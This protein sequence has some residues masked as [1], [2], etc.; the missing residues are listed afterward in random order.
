MK[1]TQLAIGV[2]ALVPLLSFGQEAMEKPH[3]G[4]LF[5]TVLE[6]ADESHALAL[7]ASREELGALRDDV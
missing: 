1:P 6:Y 7:Q 4:E 3:R 5:D 2:L